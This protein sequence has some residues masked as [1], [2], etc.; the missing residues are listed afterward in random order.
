MLCLIQGCKFIFGDELTNFAN[1]SIISR[2]LFPHESFSDELQCNLR[3]VFVMCVAK[4]VLDASKSDISDLFFS[5]T[6]ISPYFN[7]NL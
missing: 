4:N 5:I 2:K 7:H 3:G 6:Y 1:E